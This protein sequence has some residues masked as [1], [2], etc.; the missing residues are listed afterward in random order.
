[1][2]IIIYKNIFISWLFMKLKVL[3]TTFFLCTSGC[4]EVGTLLNYQKTSLN[5]CKEIEKVLD[6]EYSFFDDKDSDVHEYDEN[7]FFQDTVQLTNYSFAHE[8]TANAKELITQIVNNFKDGKL[9]HTVAEDG[10]ALVLSKDGVEQFSFFPNIQYWLD[11]QN[12]PVMISK[13]ANANRD[14]IMIALSMN[15][16][17]KAN[18][19]HC[20]YDWYTGS[21]NYLTQ[22]HKYTPRDIKNHIN[23]LQLW[24]SVTYKQ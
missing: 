24:R 20:L 6:A 8:T 15:A 7:E 16:I 12:N 11:D 5:N 17:K 13:I 22:L 14:E 2:F 23:Q 3:I 21:E 10:Y 1:M 19:T 4:G 18:I 9:K